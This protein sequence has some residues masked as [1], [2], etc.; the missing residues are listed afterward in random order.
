VLEVGGRPRQRAGRRYFVILGSE[1]WQL[2]A[3]VLRAF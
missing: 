1:A 2:G 3:R